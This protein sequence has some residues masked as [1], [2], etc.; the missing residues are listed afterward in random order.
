MIVSSKI[1]E[2]PIPH[3][4]TIKMPQLISFVYIGEAFFQHLQ[5]CASIVPPILA[6]TTL[7]NV[8]QTMIIQYLT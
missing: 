5:F 8:T 4:K 2:S 1:T 3:L 6:V 7:G